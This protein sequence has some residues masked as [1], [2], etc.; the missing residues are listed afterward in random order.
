[1]RVIGISVELGD[2]GAVGSALS[3]ESGTTVSWDIDPVQIEIGDG[4]N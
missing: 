3:T 1:M 2:E 4:L